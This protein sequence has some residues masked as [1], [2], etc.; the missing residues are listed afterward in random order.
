MELAKPK[1]VKKPARPT[2]DEFE[3]EE[4]ANTLTEAL[5][6]KNELR[7][8]VWKREDPVRGKVVKMD[9][10]T[11]LIHIENYTETIKLKFMDIL[12]V[13]RA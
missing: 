7:L 11:K 12:Y 6:E 5:Q 3:L 2:R 4:I 13:Q 8:T 10:N 1:K 9:G